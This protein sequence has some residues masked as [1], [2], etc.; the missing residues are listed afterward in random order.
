MLYD[1]ISLN[2]TQTRNN[3]KCMRTLFKNYFNNEEA[4]SW[5]LDK[6]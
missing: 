6:I 4:V 5:Q 1:E 3:M 2:N